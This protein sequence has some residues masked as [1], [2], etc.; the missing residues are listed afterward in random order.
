MRNIDELL[1]ERRRIWNENDMWSDG[2][3]AI[4]TELINNYFRNDYRNVVSF[5]DSLDASDMDQFTQFFE[6]IIAVIPDKE[7]MDY[8]ESLPAKYPSVDF[9]LDL[10]WAREKFSEKSAH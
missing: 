7:L 5:L 1:K 6:D 3:D 4:I 9:E 8:M 10:K 2:L